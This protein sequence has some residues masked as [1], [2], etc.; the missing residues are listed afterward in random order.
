L[1]P[2]ASGA[3]LRAA[4]PGRSLVLAAFAA[5]IDALHRFDRAAT[6]TLRAAVAAH[7]SI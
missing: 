2:P 7:P 5:Q 4:C 1:H 3:A 6:L